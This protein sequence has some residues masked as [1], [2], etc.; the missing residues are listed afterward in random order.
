MP[1][2]RPTWP[3]PTSATRRW[4]P[5]EDQEHFAPGIADQA[6]QETDQHRRLDR[7]IEHLPAQRALVTDRRDQAQ[8]DAA[9]VGPHEGRLAG[10]GIGTTPPVIGTQPGLVTPED[11][12][13]RPPRLRHDRWI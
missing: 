3:R 10:R 4:K 1:S 9:V 2:T 7:A 11:H 12:A 13:P 6:L 5:V 8:P